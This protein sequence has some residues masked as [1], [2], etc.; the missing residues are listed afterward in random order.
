MT[1][2]EFPAIAE[3]AQQL[4]NELC[5][6]AK[7]VLL[8]LLPH[9]ETL[10]KGNASFSPRLMLLM[11]TRIGDQ[12]SERDRQVLRIALQFAEEFQPTLIGWMTSIKRSEANT[13]SSEQVESCRRAIEL[14]ASHSADVARLVARIVAD[15]RD[16]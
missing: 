5:E 4:T 8:R 1:A 7:L 14:L 15:A 2:E 13:G 11:L 9:M 12:L 3:R 6:N 10:Q 16:S